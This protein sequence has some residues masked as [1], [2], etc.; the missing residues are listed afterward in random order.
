MRLNLPKCCSF[1]LLALSLSLLTGCAA[2]AGRGLPEN[3]NRADDGWPPNSREVA[4]G[5][6]FKIGRD[7][8]VSVR[9]TPLAVELKNVRRSWHVDARA[10]RVDAEIIITFDGEETRQ[11]L[12]AGQEK[13]VGSYDVK[14]WG[15]DPFGKTSATLV[16]TRS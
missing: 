13:T 8:K 5:E 6:K 2:S 3:A 9:E 1:L 12:Q 10:E 11:W 4:L 15:A 7:E 16:V 14:L